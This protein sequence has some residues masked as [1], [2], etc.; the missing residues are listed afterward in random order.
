MSTWTS[1]ELDIF[2]LFDYRCALNRAHKAIVLHEIVPKSLAPK[3]WNVPRNRIPLCNTCHRLV[4]DGGSKKYRKQL[5][6]LRDEVE[7]ANN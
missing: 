6:E 7:N 2:R 1:E 4:H 3:T 5:Q